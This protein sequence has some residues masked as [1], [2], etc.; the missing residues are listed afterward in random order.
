MTNG[1][2]RAKREG[3]APTQL[4]ELM[5]ALASDYWSVYYVELDRD[6]GVCFQES[7]EDKDFKIGQ[8]FPFTQSMVEYAE[9]CVLPEYREELLRF[10]SPAHIRESLQDQQVISYRYRI[11]KEGEPIYVQVRIASVHRPDDENRDQIDAIGLS[12]SNVDAET[13]ATLEQNRA[14]SDALKAAEEANAAKAAFLSNMSHEMRTPMNAIIGFTDIAMREPSASAEVKRYLAKIDTAAQHLLE[15]I[16]EILDMPRIDANTGAGPEGEDA[17]SAD[18]H[19]R[20]IL[21]AEDM[22]VNAEIMVMTL[23]M[24]GIE[25]DVAENGRVAVDMFAG[26]PAWHYDAI[27]MDMR[28]PEM[29][30]LQATR[31]IRAMDRADASEIPIIA[32]TAN[33]FDEDVERS[34]QAGLNAHLSKPVEPDVLFRTLEGFIRV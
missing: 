5:T 33:A 24:R 1:N 15:M 31:A 17:S 10:V 4:V 3:Q 19:G 7:G 16:N 20:R 12:F 25:V 14:L 26:H 9:E 29:D 23:G 30:G 11:M 28:M 34:L 27:L 18:L 13:R 21:L 6:E 32:I 22:P 2:A 8:W